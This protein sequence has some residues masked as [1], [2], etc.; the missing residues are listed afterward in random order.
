MGRR[1]KKIVENIK[2]SGIADKGKS[3]GRDANGKVYFVTGAIPG[4]IVDVLVLRKKK[5]VDQGIVKN[6]KQ[7]SPYAIEP[8]CD[9]FGVC[10]GC[11]WQNF[12]YQQQLSR[13]EQNVKDAMRRIGGLDD[14]LVEP[15]LASKEIY[16]YR[17]KLEYSFSTKR[18]LSDAEIQSD[19]KVEQSPALGFHAPGTYDKIVE[20]DTCHLQDDLSNKIRNEIGAF[21]KANEYSYY[22]FREHKGDLRNIIV[23][24]TTLGQW[25]VTISFGTSDLDKIEKLCDHLLTSFP[26]ITTL[27]Y[28]INKK[29]NDTIVDLD[30]IPYHGPGCIEEKLGDIQFQIGP[31]SFFQTNSKQ[32]KILYDHA[33]K[34]ADLNGDELVFD[35][36][37]GI[38]SIGLYLADS[39]KMVVGI[40]TIEAAVKDAEVN[41]QINEIGNAAFLV[42]DVKDVLTEEFVDSYGKPDVVITDP[43]RAGMHKDVVET[44]IE[45]KAKKIV[46]ISCNPATQAR[47][48]KLLSEIY[49][50]E[51]MQPV[52]MF[53]HTSHIENI[54]VLKLRTD[55]EN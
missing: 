28:V 36:Y 16:T 41:R 49:T 39:C 2:I 12:D 15:I 54:A 42:G 10:G 17:N 51:G 37:S 55:E 6:L 21:A 24:N 5:G 9:H 52:D 13:K 44:L 50:V 11:K 25:M 32:A 38:G 53:P 7:E 3:V 27:A 23:R 47:D 43:P 31:K 20:I 46:Y 35:L 8:K 33:K 30:V 22:D 26:Q 14:T 19:E 45:L 1:R 18:W 29:L 48:L 34:M 40:E 4:Q